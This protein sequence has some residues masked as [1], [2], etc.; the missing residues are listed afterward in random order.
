[1]SADIKLN[2]AQISKIIQYSKSFGPWL[3]SLVK[4]STNKWVYFYF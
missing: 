4:K 1:M 2:Q 3:G